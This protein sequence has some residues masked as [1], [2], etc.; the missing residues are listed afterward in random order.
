MIAQAVLVAL[1]AAWLS[2]GAYENIRHPD[3]NRSDVA[4]VLALEALADQPQILKQVAYRRIA[5]PAIVRVVFGAIVA[6]ES[7]VALL[8][9]FSALLLAGAVLGLVPAELAHTVAILAVLGF[10]AIWAAFLI[11]GQWFYY[12]YGAYGQQSHFLL[13]LWGIATLLVLAAWPAR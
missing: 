13:T 6:A 4:K 10:T 11:G 9:W 1:Q 3:A 12:W 7:L 2:L 8:L 5:D